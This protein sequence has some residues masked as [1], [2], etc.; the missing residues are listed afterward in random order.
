MTMIESHSRA[1]LEALAAL[2]TSARA[3]HGGSPWQ[4]AGV[5]AAL[6][7]A[8]NRPEPM[9]LARLT[10][11]A[12]L[13]AVNP[14]YMTPMMIAKDGDHWQNGIVKTPTFEIR[15]QLPDDCGICGRPKNHCDDS[16]EYEPREGRY[17]RADEGLIDAVRG[18]I[19][20]PIINDELEESA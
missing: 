14:G 4:L 5:R 8:G 1:T 12:L 15:H 2:V 20:K 10:N 13:A 7:A 6:I 11:A 9:S 3:D 16:H 19:Q 17:E 18:R